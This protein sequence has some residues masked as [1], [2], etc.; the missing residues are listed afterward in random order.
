MV[1]RNTK[2]V[3]EC[4][5]EYVLASMIR[6]D[7]PLC[8]WNTQSYKCVRLC[9]CVCVSACVSVSLCVC[10]RSVRLYVCV[11]L[12]LYSTQVLYDGV[13]FSNYP[14][15]ERDIHVDSTHFS[16]LFPQWK[17]NT[18]FHCHYHVC[19]S[20]WICDWF[21]PPIFAKTLAAATATAH[22]MHHSFRNNFQWI[23]FIRW[24]TL[25]HIQFG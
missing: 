16:Q 4:V 11:L 14:Q 13:T 7:L 25:R 24:I 1:K 15:R 2:T 20:I 5:C 23:T 10:V 17:R 12:F 21:V 6:T 8:G 22:W 3:L 18:V 9:V 19:C